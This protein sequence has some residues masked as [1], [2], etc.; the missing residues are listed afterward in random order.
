M[1]SSAIARRVTEAHAFDAPWVVCRDCLTLHRHGQLRMAE[2]GREA[3]RTFSQPVADSFAQTDLLGQ[4]D[5]GRTV[6]P[7]QRI[8]RR[9]VALLSG[10][11]EDGE[12]VANLNGVIAPI[13]C[14]FVI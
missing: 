5:H 3:G 9:N 12:A 13:V 10:L 2:L 11:H 1:A 8:T 7:R 4:G 14:L 6:A